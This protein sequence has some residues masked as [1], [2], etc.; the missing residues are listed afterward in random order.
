M[1]FS[2]CESI[3]FHAYTILAY[4]M[5]E[6]DIKVSEKESGRLLSNIFDSFRR[7]IKLFAEKN[8]DVQLVAY[9]IALLVEAIQG[10]S[11]SKS[12]SDGSISFCSSRS[13]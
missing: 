12:P 8:P 2:P 7:Q 11:H 1:T 5:G 10:N 9:N 13:T 4:I 3:V 6:D